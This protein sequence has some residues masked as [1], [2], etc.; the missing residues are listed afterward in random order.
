MNLL[1]I[2]TW[3]WMFLITIVITGLV[4]YAWVGQNK[5][6]QDLE[7]C[8]SEL[9]KRGGPL[10]LLGHQEICG[11]FAKERDEEMTESMNNLREWLGLKLD[12]V[13]KDIKNLSDS[14]E[15]KVDNKILR[16]L[17]KLNRSG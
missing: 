12:S 4:K 11:R 2:P 5:R 10:T 16:E 8:K 13:Q 15:D 9:N 17:Q 7:T 14:M 6:I 3:V 1:A